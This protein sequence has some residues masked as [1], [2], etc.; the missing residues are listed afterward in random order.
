MQAM[1]ARRPLMMLWAQGRYSEVISGHGDVM[2]A[3]RLC[4]DVQLVEADHTGE[5]SNAVKVVLSGSG[6]A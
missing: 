6:H 1:Y 5:L 3:H 2:H 4:D